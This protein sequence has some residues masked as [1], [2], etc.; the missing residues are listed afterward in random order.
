MIMAMES[1]SGSMSTTH[2]ASARQAMEKLVS[3]AMQS[4]EFTRDSAVMKLARCIDLVVPAADHVRPRP[5][6]SVR[7]QRVVDE[8]LAITP[9]RGA[10]G[11]ATTTVFRRDRRRPGGAAH[12]LPD[13]LRDP[14]AL[15]VHRGRSSCREAL[16][17]GGA[18]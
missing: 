6:G 16:S 3:C 1:G 12:V 9:G 14:G 2:A 10:A 4:G 18:A 5:D 13:H 8:M 7:K 15:R 17:D 11:Y